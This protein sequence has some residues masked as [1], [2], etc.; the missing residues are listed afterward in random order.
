VASVAELS[1]PRKQR[2]EDMLQIDKTDRVPQEQLKQ[3]NKMNTEQ[4]ITKV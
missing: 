2:Y 3:I 1:T 4:L